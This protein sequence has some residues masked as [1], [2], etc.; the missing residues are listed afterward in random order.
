MQTLGECSH[1]AW[2]ST[3]FSQT[4]ANVCLMHVQVCTSV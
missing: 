1:E 2:T 4:F 3:Y